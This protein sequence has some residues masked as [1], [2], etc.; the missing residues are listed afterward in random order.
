MAPKPS[1]PFNEDTD[2][3]PFMLFPEL[4]WP[5]SPLKDDSR[6]YR[7]EAEAATEAKEHRYRARRGSMTTDD[8]K[9]MIHITYGSGKFRTPLRKS[10]RGEAG[11]PMDIDG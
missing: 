6:R 10:V 4:Q 1:I 7:E 9:E 3:D 2:L 5:Y 8:L 11:S